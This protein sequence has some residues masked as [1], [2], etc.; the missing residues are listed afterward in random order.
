MKVLSSFI[1][2][3]QSGNV[4]NGGI[5]GPVVGRPLASGLYSLVSRYRWTA[6]PWSA[7]GSGRRTHFRA[8]DED[9]HGRASP[10]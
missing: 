7:T 1:A 10:L 5:Q 4:L 9:T 2:S 8:A 3:F 6:G